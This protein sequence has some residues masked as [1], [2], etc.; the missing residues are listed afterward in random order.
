MDEHREITI[1]WYRLLIALWR[2]AGGSQ[3]PIAQ[4]VFFLL[5]SPGEI[6]AISVVTGPIGFLQLQNQPGQAPVPQ[7]LG[8]SPTTFLA[9]VTGMMSVFAGRTD[10]SRDGGSTFYP[11]SLTGAAVP[12]LKGD[13]VKISWVG[14]NK[15]TAV[16]WPSNV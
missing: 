10:L 5:T 11:I 16:W 8:A 15:P 3:V 4:A 13:I 12:M 6:E 2:L 9:G 1:P 7:T 14:A